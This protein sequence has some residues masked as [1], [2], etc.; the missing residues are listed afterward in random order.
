M[1]QIPQRRL[2]RLDLVA[3]REARERRSHRRHLFPERRNLQIAGFRLGPGAPQRVELGGKRTKP[4]PQLIAGGRTGRGAQEIPVGRRRNDLRSA[5]WRPACRRHD[6]IRRSRPRSK[7]LLHVRALRFLRFLTLRPE[8]IEGLTSVERPASRRDL[9]QRRFQVERAGRRRRVQDR[10]GLL[11]PAAGGSERGGGRGL[12]GVLPPMRRALRGLGCRRRRPEPF[13][14]V[15]WNAAQGGGACPIGSGRTWM[16]ARSA[17]GPR[18][19]F[20]PLLQV[21]RVAALDPKRLRRKAITNETFCSGP[22]FRSR[23]LRLLGDRPVQPLVEGD[24]GAICGPF[25]DIAS[26][27]ADVSV[28]HA[29]L[30]LMPSTVAGVCDAKRRAAPP[31]RRSFGCHGEETVKERARAA[32]PPTKAA[33]QF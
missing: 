2:E 22:R 31:P 29:V 9:R 1:R 3:G 4:L 13:R 24:A 7:R 20:Q 19:R 26:G 33:K 8:T 6:A 11:R 5:R 32:S 16:R 18:R 23:S 12:A 27:G 14:F 30:L 15:A 28:P 25:R 17:V 10:R 21:P